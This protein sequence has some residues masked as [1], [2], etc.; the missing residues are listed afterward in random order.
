MESRFLYVVLYD[1]ISVGFIHTL[2]SEKYVG[3]H[4]KDVYGVFEG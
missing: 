4:S 3:V 1:S 2:A